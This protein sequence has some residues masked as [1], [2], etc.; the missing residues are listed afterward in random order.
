MVV[1]E[2][3]FYGLND[4]DSTKQEYGR[5]TIEAID[6]T[7]DSEDGQMSFKL[8]RAGTEEFTFLQFST[9]ADTASFD[10][11]QL[12]LHK[13]LGSNPN[14]T[15]TLSGEDIS[16]VDDELIATLEFEGRDDGGL[17]NFA[18]ITARTGDVTGATG[19]GVLGV[20]VRDDN[21]E[22]EYITIDGEAQ[23]VI[24]NSGIVLT[25][26]SPV[27]VTPVLGTPSSGTLDMSNITITGSVSEFNAALQCDSFIFATD[28]ISALSASTVAQY[29]T[30]LTTETFAY[31]GVANA[32]GTVNQD[33]TSNGKWQE[34]GVAISPIG[35]QQFWIPASSFKP[36]ANDP[37]AGLTTREFGANNQNIEA[38]EFDDAADSSAY[39]TFR[40]PQNWDLG[41]ITVN[42]HWFREDDE[43]TPESKTISFD[44][45]AISLSNFVAIGSV[46]Y[47]TPVTITDTSDSS[48]AEDKINIST[49]SGNITVQGTPADGD[50]I[51]LRITDDVTDSTTS[52]STYLVGVTIEY[53]TDAAVSTG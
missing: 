27:F 28:N 21:V 53:T 46:S 6:V 33:I 18:K 42:Y 11:Q 26:T 52:G 48:A 43:A 2:I 19:S 9:F 17:V 51:N 10:A 37:A 32:W 24:I 47:G 44:I 8:T 16:P 4:V 38:M 5:I 15:L 30:S 13:A 45:S 3:V 14:A 12:I 49:F 23:Q 50:L 7:K 35:K 25:A 40:M 39:V 1:D 41:V 34:G 36:Q 20:F 31:I 22:T 29:N